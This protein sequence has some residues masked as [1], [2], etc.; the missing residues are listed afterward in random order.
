MV[1]ADR[2]QPPWQASWHFDRCDDAPRWDAVWK[3]GRVDP[4][5]AISDQDSS[6]A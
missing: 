2:R 6:A 4:A 1:D 5:R 3:L